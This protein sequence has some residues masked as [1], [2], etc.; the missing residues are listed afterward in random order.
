MCRHRKRRLRLRF[1]GP[2]PRRA[3]GRP[4]VQGSERTNRTAAHRASGARTDDVAADRHTAVN[5]AGGPARG[6]PDDH[7]LA[8]GW[9]FSH[10]WGFEI[11]GRSYG[12]P[13][14]REFD[15]EPV[16]Y[17][18]KGLRLGTVIA[19]GVDRFV[20]VCDYGDNWRHEVI[21]EE[22]RDGDP[23]GEYPASNLRSG[24]PYVDS[25]RRYAAII[26]N[27]MDAS[28]VARTDFGVMGRQIAVLY[29]AC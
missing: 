3:T 2:I 22:V 14:F 23:D 16:I 25:A 4:M 13:S 19:R 9:T 7:R 12:D 18:A 1:G 11:D 21:V 24:Y 29:P 20:C 5:N 17:K 10:L 6:N 15:D 26:A 8:I 27:C 28:R